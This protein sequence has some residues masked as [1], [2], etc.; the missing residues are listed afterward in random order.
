M[1]EKVKFEKR[2]SLKEKPDTANLGFG[3][4]FTDYM[5]SVDYDADQGWHDMKIVPYAP[6]E[7]S[8]AAQGLHYGQAVFEGLKAYKHNGEVVLF[9]PDQNFKRINDSLARL[10]MPKVRSEE[11]RVGKECRSRW[12]PY[13]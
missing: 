5:L 13:H 9:R 10:E 12:S 8:P 6:F 3:Q 7:I 1:S 2:E 4:Y 11:R